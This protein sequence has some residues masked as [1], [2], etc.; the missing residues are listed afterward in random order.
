MRGVF[1]A[2]RIAIFHRVCSLSCVE[3]F[4]RSPHKGEHVAKFS[5]GYRLPLCQQVAAYNLALATAQ[6]S[7]FGSK[8]P[9]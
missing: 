5:A 9:L 3:V 1:D 8:N 7:H 2:V 4:G 6:E